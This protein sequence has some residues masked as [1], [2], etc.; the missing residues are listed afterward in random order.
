MEDNSR[1]SACI[2]RWGFQNKKAMQFGNLVLPI[3][4]KLDNAEMTQFLLESIIIRIS[5]SVEEF[6]T[7]IISIA[8][9]RSESKMKTYFMKYGNE[10]TKR[11]IKNGCNLGMLISFAVAEISFKDNAKKFERVFNYL[12]GSV[13]F[14]DQDSKD[15]F[16]DMIL[17]RNIIVHSGG[18]PNVSH[19]RQI[20]HSNAIKISANIGEGKAKHSFYKL[21]LTDI[22]F[23]G[24]LIIALGKIMIHIASIIGQNST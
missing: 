13:P 15:Y 6:L 2:N 4:Q 21:E 7:C 19:A 20:R 16:L 3:S 8:T 1:Y 11:Q 24:Y 12:F 5:C 10:E 14:P 23:F 9:A 18:W 17:V 22:K